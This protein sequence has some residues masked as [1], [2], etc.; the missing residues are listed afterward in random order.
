MSYSSERN[1]RAVEFASTEALMQGRVSNQRKIDLYIREGR[2]VFADMV[3]DEVRAIDAELYR[4][5][6]DSHGQPVQKPEPQGEVVY[7]TP[8]RRSWSWRIFN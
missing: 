7:P 3:S 1:A 2:F 8:R 6:L 4:R 5:G